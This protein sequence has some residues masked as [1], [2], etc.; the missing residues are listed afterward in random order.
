MPVFRRQIRRPV[1]RVIAEQVRVRPESA[2]A[3]VLF[4]HEPAVDR[5]RSTR[6]QPHSV[7]IHDEMVVAR[8]PNEPLGR[9]FEQRKLKQ[10]PAHR[11]ESSPHVGLHPGL[12]GSARI[13]FATDVDHRERQD[14]AR[15]DDL[16]RLARDLDETHAEHIG[17]GHELRERALEQRRVDRAID[18]DV[19]ADVV[20]GTCRVELLGKPDAELR[21]SQRERV[22]IRRTPLVEPSLTIGIKTQI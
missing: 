14:A 13:A 12:R 7:A 9:N 8:V 21:A 2:L 3:Q 17:F 11:N 20:G 19:F 4:A 10:W 15:I 5:G 16:P 18:L 22:A 1:R 6:E